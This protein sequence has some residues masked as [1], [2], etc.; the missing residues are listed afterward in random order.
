[1]YDERM[2]ATLL[3][4]AAIAH[5]EPI[6]IGLT[7]SATPIEAQYVAA[8]KPDSPRV[9]LIGG[10]DGQRSQAV[11]A[12]AEKY[13]KQAR[14]PY[15]LYSIALANP[16]KAKLAFP[17]A[18]AAYKDNPESHYIWRW[19][20]ALPADL[21]LT[22]GPDAGLAAELKQ[23]PARSGSLKSVPKNIAASE[24]HMEIAR[25]IARTP[26][27]TAAALAPHYGHTL[28]EVAYIPAV[29][30]FGQMRLGNLAEVARLA[31][32][33]INGTKNSL[34]K[35]TSSHLSGHL[36]FAELYR[37]TRNPLYLDR[38]RAAANL[39]FTESGAMRASMPMHNEMSDSV[40]MGTPIL[41][42]AGH[43]TGEAKYF[44]MAYRHF[45]FMEK[46]CLRPEGIYRHSPLDEAAWGR[47]NAFPAFGLALTLKA[48]PR[49]NANTDEM[50]RAFQNL[51]AAL[52]RFQDEHTG[53][54]HQVVDRRGSYAEFTSTSMIAVSM[55]IGIRNGWL[56]A[57]SYQPRVDRAWRAI[58]ARIGDDGVLLDVC[59][60]TGKQK[61]LDDYLRR[62]AI[63]DRDPRGGAMALLFATELTSPK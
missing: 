5:A 35:A 63:F 42:A 56:D 30:L 16:D 32:P 55:L 60:S 40:F 34:D 21:V 45:K 47:G 50:L 49:G 14:H 17:P 8:S 28:P 6:P 62:V 9:V 18:G 36:L 4:L 46:L 41:A 1:M 15:H 26:S 44:D 11:R 54:W 48:M 52:S 13:E 27:Q 51:M 43:L 57:G 37:V 39:G 3:L 58:N 29:A 20:G 19:L 31:A 38:V 12:E 61:S 2:R 24:A 10:F 59:E 22:A 33:F 25:R 53:M 7:A 23:I